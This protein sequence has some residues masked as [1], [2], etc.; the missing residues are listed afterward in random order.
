MPGWSKE[1]LRKLALSAEEKRLIIMT[2]FG[3]GALLAVIA[4]VLLLLLCSLIEG[5][6]FNV[7]VSFSWLSFIVERCYFVEYWY[8]Y[9]ILFTAL[10]ISLMRIYERLVPGYTDMLI[11]LR[12][13][14]NGELIRMP[15][16]YYLCSMGFTN[17]FEELLFRVG[18][19][20]LLQYIVAF[21]LDPLSSSGVALVLSSILFW[22]IHA[23]YRTVGGALSTIPMALALGW[24]YL[25]TGSLLVVFITHLFY[26]LVVMYLERYQ[27]KRDR[28]YFR[29]K[30]PSTILTDMQN[31]E[32]ESG[33]E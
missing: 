11:T 9:P 21:F 5:N 4:L 17:F 26:N 12:Q 32:V 29:G 8:L 14:V 33:K 16:W 22:Y 19:I 3:S 27:M 28:N 23:S 13:G 1:E 25:Y 15:F 18:L 24:I 10:F 2:T 20:G 6:L 7:L 30:V 31:E